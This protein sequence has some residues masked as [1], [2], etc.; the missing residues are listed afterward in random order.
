MLRCR[1]M[2]IRAGLGRSGGRALLAALLTSGCAP[3]GTPRPGPGEPPLTPRVLTSPTPPPQGV[4][5]VAV[6]FPTV[7]RHALS[8]RQS[9]NGARLAAQDLN[10]RGGIN[11]RPI[12][13]LEYETGS[14]FLDA[15]AAAM[16]AVQAGALAIVGSNSSDL[17]MAIAEAAEAQGVGQASNVSTAQ[18]LTVDPARGPARAF[19]F[20]FCGTDVLI[21]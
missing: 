20:R 12:A 5:P 13:L 11:G 10:R 19:V 14:Y 18:D 2:A 6:V 16:L 21:G 3:Q 1:L 17:S 7:G 4:L 15:R 9:L 8:G